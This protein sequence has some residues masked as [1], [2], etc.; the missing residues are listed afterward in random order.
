MSLIYKDQWLSYYL[1]Q[2]RDLKEKQE[3]GTSGSRL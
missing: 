1:A 2:T 3:P